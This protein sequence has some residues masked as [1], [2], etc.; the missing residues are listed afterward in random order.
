MVAPSCRV[1]KYGLPRM[2]HVPAWELL[3]L[4]EVIAGVRL[5]PMAGAASP[6]TPVSVRGWVANFGLGMRIT[7]VCCK[8]HIAASSSITTAMAMSLRAARLLGRRQ[9]AVC[10]ECHRRPCIL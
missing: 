4:C 5:R 1:L 10:R 6:L 3:A 9:L 2:L 7:T 8:H